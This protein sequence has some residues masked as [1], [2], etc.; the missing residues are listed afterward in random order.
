MF[1][2]HSIRKLFLTWRKPITLSNSR[3]W[4]ELL[5]QRHHDDLGEA[6]TDGELW[7]VWDTSVPSSGDVAAEIE[8][9]FGLR[10]QQ[11]ICHRRT[12]FRQSCR[13]DNVHERGCRQPTDRNRIDMVSQ[14]SSSRR[15]EYSLQ[16]VGADPR[17]YRTHIFNRQSRAGIE[18]LGRNW[19]RSAKSPDSG[20]RHTAGHMLLFHHFQ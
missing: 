9:R 7:K 19:K 6:T 4:L 12:V 20:P 18:R 15:P 10:R 14:V 3:I 11:S 5:D 16:T 8:R 17:I 2:S 13:Y 1:P